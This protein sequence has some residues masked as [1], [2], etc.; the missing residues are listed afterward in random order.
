MRFAYFDCAP[1]PSFT[2]KTKRQ[3]GNPSRFLVRQFP[4]S[5]FIL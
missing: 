1:A 5:S 2:A 4:D 3:A